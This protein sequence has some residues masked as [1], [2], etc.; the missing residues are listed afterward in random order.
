LE[1]PPK[2][3]VFLVSY[4]EMRYD[5][6]RRKSTRDVIFRRPGQGSHQRVSGRGFIRKNENMLG[7]GRAYN[8]VE[9]K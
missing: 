7:R 5:M 4:P 2:M 3:A 1:K 9:K 8:K 6:F